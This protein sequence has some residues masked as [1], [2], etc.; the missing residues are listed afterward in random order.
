MA[1]TRPGLTPAHEA[2]LALMPEPGRGPAARK[3]RHVLAWVLLSVAALLLVATVVAAGLAVAAH[4]SDQFV[5]VDVPAASLGADELSE[6]T[7]WAHTPLAQPLAPVVLTYHDIQPNPVRSR[8]VV[9]PDAFARQMA[10]LKAA[11][12]H[13][14][15]A[16]QFLA[17]QR[18]TFTPPSRSVLL[19]FDDGT[20]GTWR[21]ADSILERYGF[22]AVSFVITRRVGTRKPYYL[23]W[24]LIQ[25]MHASGR[26]DFES[27]TSNLHTRVPTSPGGQL[28]GALSNRIY[29]DGRLETQAEF[30]TRVR[31]DLLQSISDLTSHGLPRPQMFAYPFSDVVAK[32]VEDQTVAVPR[33][34]VSALFPAA[35]VDVEPGALPATRREVLKQVIERAEVFHQDDERSVFHRLQQMA[36]LPVSSM[37]PLRVD[38]H[39]FEDGNAHP[40]PVKVVGDQLVVDA[41]TETYVTGSWAPQRTAD[42]V[43]YTVSCRIAGLLPNG[44]SSAGLIVRVGSGREVQVRVS[45]HELQVS[46][47]NG[48]VGP[49]RE[50]ASASA[51]L[52][53]VTVLRGSTEVAVDGVTRLVLPSASDPSTFGGFGVVF[54]RHDPALNFPV[55]VGFHV[56][57]A[58]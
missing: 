47:A 33:A 3:P 25:R 5:R 48:P 36:T 14:L 13:S 39:W 23:T 28:G 56:G 55:F 54:S 1:V 38:T 41:A 49:P 16:D 27:H 22:T 18:G 20:A 34:I 9:T 51:H 7:G 29:L 52:L 24:D 58:T 21:Y 46:G 30:E 53:E 44:R 11:G 45:Q 4:S 42:W 32:G 35:F 17:Y 6:F 26:W 10:M 15:T 50:L 43:N 19:T 31:K 2:A 8:Y 40:A 12:Y 57:A 37:D